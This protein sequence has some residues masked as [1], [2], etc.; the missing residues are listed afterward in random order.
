MKEINWFNIFDLFAAANRN[1]KLH[2][3]F[4]FG[5]HSVARHLRAKARIGKRK[6]KR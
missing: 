3:P 1:P 4:K 5:R 2:V 6:A